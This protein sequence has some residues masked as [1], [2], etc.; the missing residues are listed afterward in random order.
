MAAAS[1][2][3]TRLQQ[4]VKDAM[5]ARDKTRL[6]VLRMVTAAVKQREVDERT[7]LDDVQVLEVLTR[8]V[9]QRR[10]SIAQYRDAGRDDLAAVEEAELDVLAGFMSQPLSEAELQAMVDQ[11]IADT[12]AGGM[13]DMGRVMGQLKPQVQGRADMGAVS[14]MVKARLAS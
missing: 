4:A 9:K 7:E 2:L 12:G 5:R 8:M 3:K 1:E 10:E 6:G 14:K 13:Q 11:V